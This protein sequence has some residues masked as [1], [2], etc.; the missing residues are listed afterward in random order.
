MTRRLALASAAFL[1]W[2]FQPKPAEAF[3]SISVATFTATVTI[4]APGPVPTG[5]L[6][7]QATPLP[8]TALVGKNLTIPVTV[9]SS[10]GPVNPN[11]LMVSI[12]YQLFDANNM[13]V[14]QPAQTQVQ[15]VPGAANGNTLSG[16]AIVPRS[17]LTPV[18][19]G[20]SVAYVFQALKVG[21]NSGTMLNS[22]NPASPAISNITSVPSLETP[23]INPFITVTTDT[24]CRPVDPSGAMVSAPDLA[25]GD[26]R[27][28]V[29]LPQG[30]VPSP[31]NLCIH[32]EQNPAYFPAGPLGTQPAAIYTITLDNNAR[33]A[34]TAQLVLSYP[35]DLNGRV[36]D[37]N[38]DP[39]TLGIYWLDT[40]PNG[41][42]WLALSR[43]TLDSTLHTLT[44]TT[45][46]F[47]TFALFPA[48]TIGSADLRPAQRIITPNGDGINDTANFGTG[49]DQ[50]KIFDVR[51]RRV[52]TIPGPSPV[53]DGKNDDG[54]VV[55]SGVYI[56]QY[57][58]NGD[59]VS[60]VIGVA[61]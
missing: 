37:L 57:T 3:I 12:V 35:S 44:G 50:V 42:Q 9:I 47:S 40:S 56:Y 33:L 36:L 15:F 43:A 46:H 39:S 58:I 61:K 20:G 34:G 1:M 17:Q 28:G 59:R 22:K 16:F 11:N 32:V 26:G 60:G 5:A 30:A 52:R 49:I 23:A 51:G 53:W 31:A 45:G 24:W 4:G 48:G 21:T 14:T 7:I 10:S 6:T 41:G 13:P 54:Q 29:G 2:A 19:Q 25:E 27:T 55:E 18:Q 8:G 38:A